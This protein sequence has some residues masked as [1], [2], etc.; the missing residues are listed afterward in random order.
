MEL[1]T[2]DRNEFIEVLIAVNPVYNWLEDNIDRISYKL[3]K[4]FIT[5]IVP[6]GKAGKK[7]FKV[8][9][10]NR[11]GFIKELWKTYN[12]IE[13]LYQEGD[14]KKKSYMELENLGY[15]GIFLDEKYP[16]NDVLK[17]LNQE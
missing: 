3:L 4:G 9:A 16:V 7:Y 14:L 1:G 12:K 11:N 6:L 13:K 8:I 10:H 2:L 5:N 17:Y 15:T